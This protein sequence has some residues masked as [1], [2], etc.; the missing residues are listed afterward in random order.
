MQASVL[1]VYFAVYAHLLLFSAFSFFCA[2]SR[3]FVSGAT[4]LSILSLASLWSPNNFSTYDCKFIDWLFSLIKAIIHWLAFLFLSRYLL[5]WSLSAWFDNFSGKHLLK[6]IGKQDKQ[7]VRSSVNGKKGRK[8]GRKEKRRRARGTALKYWSHFSGQVGGQARIRVPI[9]VFRYL[10]PPHRA[11]YLCLGFT[12]TGTPFLPAYRAPEAAWRGVA[13]AV[14]GA[15][16]KPYELVFHGQR[17]SGSN[18]QLSLWTQS[19]TCCQAWCNGRPS[20]KTTSWHAMITPA[21]NGR[22]FGCEPQ[23]E[24]Y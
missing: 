7:R 16:F 6:K 4:L 1:P 24:R 11:G 20:G 13:R 21:H 9:L 14:C 22:T 12:C 8:E 23:T 15:A 5:F 18:Q 19:K 17:N 10:T 3:Y 2:P